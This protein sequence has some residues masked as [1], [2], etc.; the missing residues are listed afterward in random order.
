MCFPIPSGPGY[1]RNQALTVQFAVKRSTYARA[2]DDLHIGRDDVGAEVRAAAERI[3]SNGRHAIRDSDGGEAG[4]TAERVISNGRYTVRDRIFYNFP[5]WV[6]DERFAVRGEK[7]SVDAFEIWIAFRDPNLRQVR[8]SERIPGNDRYTRRNGNGSEVEAVCECTCH[9][10][11][12]AFR[13]GVMGLIVFVR[14]IDKR[15]AV[16][17]KFNTVDNLSADC[18]TSVQ[19][20]T[21]HGTQK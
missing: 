2:F 19:C 1:L 11:R 8:V 21:L 7:S 15:F 12:Y 18:D 17:R 16:F 9:N 10:V 4:A 20:R 13:D 5:V 14:K 3:F 6:A